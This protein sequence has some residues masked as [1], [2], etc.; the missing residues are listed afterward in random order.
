MGVFDNKLKQLLQQA[1]DELNVRNEMETNKLNTYIAR[2]FRLS[3]S[4]IGELLATHI[5]RV[6]KQKCRLK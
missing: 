2:R 1:H 6:N 5:E 3:E 4:E